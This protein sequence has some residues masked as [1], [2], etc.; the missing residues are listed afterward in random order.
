MP[1]EINALESDRFGITAAHLIDLNASLDDVND[2]AAAANVD[3]ITVRV[4]ADDLPRVHA[5]ED[6]GFR[7]MD[8][9]VYYERRLGGNDPTRLTVPDISIRLATQD[10][11]QSVSSIAQTAFTNYMGH[12]HADPRLNNSAAD[13]A[14]VQWAEDSILLMKEQTPVLVA[15]N[16]DGT[17]GFLAMKQSSPEEFEVKLNAVH[18]KNQKKGIYSTLLAEALNIACKTSAKRLIIST[19]INN[20]GVKRA[21]SR[22][23]F[24]H[25]HSIYTFHKWY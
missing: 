2:A 4:N 14:Y 18:P 17:I 8:T 11:I 12:Y 5:L 16:K 10:D 25:F 3:M 23:G 6:N 9:L 22:L 13:A 1:I 19:Q 24:E 20:F 21:W 15:C 7:L